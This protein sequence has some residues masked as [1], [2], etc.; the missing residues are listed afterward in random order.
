MDKDEQD[1]EGLVTIINDG[2]QSVLTKWNVSDNML[3]YTKLIVLLVVVIIIVYILQFLVRYIL[4]AIFKR[5]HKISKLNIFGY[6]VKN[7]LPHFLALVVPYSFVRGCIPIVFMDFKSFISPLIKLTDIYMV[8]MIIWT[9]MTVV[10]SLADII[11]EKP[12]FQN[13]PMKSYV[14][15]IQ[16]IFFIFGAVAIFCILTGKSVATFFAAMGAASAVLMLMFK[17][18]IMGFVGSIQISTNDMVRLGDWITMSKYGADGN[19]EEI[20]LTTVKVRN[21]DQTITTIPTYSLISDSFQ[22]WRG[23]QESGGRRF[24]RAI[25]IKYDSI[26]FLT[27]E[28]LNKYKNIV[29]LTSYID[30]KQKEY[31]ELNKTLSIDPKFPVGE[32]RLTNNDLYIQ[33]GISYLRSNPGIRSNMAILFRQLSPSTQGIPLEI[34]AFTATTVLDDYEIIVAEV[35]NHLVCMASY[36]DLQIYEES[37]GSDDYNVFLN[38]LGE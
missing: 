31:A 17:D 4:T 25:N 10:K 11:Q 3:I 19:V 13:K 8:F 2:L 30:K 32:Y 14:Q 24:K 35:T 15:V 9:I 34:Y 23:M 37:A 1:L 5:I 18:T 27:D 16:I 26:K 21:F 38:K 20:N 6:A 33:Y 7:R 22:N 28:D 29:S 12:A 36:F